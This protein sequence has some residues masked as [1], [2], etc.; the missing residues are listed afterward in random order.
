MIIDKYQ[1]Y[2]LYN[3]LKQIWNAKRIIGTSFNDFFECPLDEYL[4]NIFIVDNNSTTFMSNYAIN[5]VNEFNCNIFDIYHWIMQTCV[6]TL[7]DNS[8][9]DLKNINS[10]KKLNNYKIF[11]KSNE[12]DKQI[13]FINKL[14]IERNS[15][16]GE[17]T[18]NRFSLYDLNNEQV[19]EA[20]NLFKN[21]NFHP[22]FY[23]RGLQANKF[24]ININTIKDIDYK[25]FITFSKII[26][27]INKEYSEK[28]K[29]KN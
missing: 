24:K 26:I 18:D 19:N 17:L 21:N 20:Y 16:I 13:N 23:I 8:F 3:K 5:L 11:V 4:I 6:K 28:N 25:R 2:A 10:A 9:P 22:E 29:A 15:G 12:I 27:K 14:V 7:R 1:I